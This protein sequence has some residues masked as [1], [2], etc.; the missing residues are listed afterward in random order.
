MSPPQITEPLSTSI[1]ETPT[2]PEI[3]PEKPKRPDKI[4]QK[5]IKDDQ[6]NNQDLISELNKSINNKIRKNKI[7]ENIKGMA[8]SLILTLTSSLVL[9]VTSSLFLEDENIPKKDYS[10]I[11]EIETELDE[12]QKRTK[13]SDPNS[14]FAIA[15]SAKHKTLTKR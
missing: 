8:S 12:I 6:S 5:T 13:M 9:T 14:A 3:K 1:P 2:R 15:M 10:T 11:N 4:K 7:E